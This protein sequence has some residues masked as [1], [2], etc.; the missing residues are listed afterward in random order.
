MR[1]EFEKELELE[2][3]E[4]CNC[5]ECTCCADEEAEGSKGKTYTEEEVL[6]L[7]E[8]VTPSVHVDTED[9]QGFSLNKKEFKKGLESVGFVCG[10]IAALVSVGVSEDRAVEYI[11]NRET[12]EHNQ[13]L[14]VLINEQ[15]VAL[16]KL[17]CE[18]V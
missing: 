1:E 14:Q 6:Q 10:Q 16:Q 9:C 15:Q 12:I 17:A 8:Q 4:L 13:D 11:I 18:Q 2:T 5:E 3:E 7:L